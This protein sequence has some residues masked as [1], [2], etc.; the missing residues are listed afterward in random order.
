[1]ASTLDQASIKI[2]WQPIYLVVSVKLV[3]YVQC[4]AK[5]TAFPCLLFL[6]SEGKAGLS[7]T[8]FFPF[9][10]VPFIHFPWISPVCFLFILPVSPSRSFFNYSF[11]DS[12]VFSWYFFF[13][14]TFSCWALSFHQSLLLILSLLPYSPCTHFLYL[15]LYL[16][17]CFYSFQSIWASFLHAV[18]SQE[19]R[20]SLDWDFRTDISVQVFC[21]CH[22]RD[23]VNSFP[24]ETLGILLYSLIDWLP[25]IYFL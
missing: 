22:Q 5:L 1:M 17:Q 2:C 8:V 11:L 6:L 18:F 10:G 23:G 15:L 4:E 7:K 24:K 16:T 12:F 13:F 19:P 14:F 25:F 9:T 3:Q 21:D 20:D